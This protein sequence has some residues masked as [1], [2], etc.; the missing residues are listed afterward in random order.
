M[1]A[2][3]TH[4]HRRGTTG[5]AASE[6]MKQRIASYREYLASAEWKLRRDDAL[7]RA[8]YRCQS[9]TCPEP[10]L[11]SLSDEDLRFVCEEYLPPHHYRLEVHHLTYERLG[12]EH[13]DDL[14]VLCPQ[15]H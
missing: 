13:P 1:A 14:I 3:G 2:G 12:N 4:P 6:P 5:L 11:R 8:Y 7:H 9:P 10:Q 15:C